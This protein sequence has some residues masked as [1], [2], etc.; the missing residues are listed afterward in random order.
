MFSGLNH[1]TMPMNF[2]KPFTMSENTFPTEQQWHVLTAQIHKERPDTPPQLQV[3][4]VSGKVSVVVNCDNKWGLPSAGYCLLKTFSTYLPYFLSL[5][6]F[7]PLHLQG[8]FSFSLHFSSM[9]HPADA[10]TW[11]CH[12]LPQSFW[13]NGPKCCVL[14]VFGGG[15]CGDGVVVGGEWWMSAKEGEEEYAYW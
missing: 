2:L 15:G 10:F 12:C 9:Q 4:G 14:Y 3:L 6:P 5:A 1:T 8:S 13:G 7:F 11:A